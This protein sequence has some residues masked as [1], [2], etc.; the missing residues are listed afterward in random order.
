MEKY[1]DQLLQD[2]EA[3]IEIAKTPTESR[4]YEI[5]EWLSEEEEDRTAPVRELE[6]LTGIKQEQLPPSSLLADDQITKLTK[7]LIDLLNTHNWSFVMQTEVPEKFQ[8][9]CIRQ[10]FKQTVKVYKWKMGFFENC[11]PGTEHHTC[12]L[13]E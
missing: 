2:I 3:A 7:A 9:E 4:S 10:N 6:D 5:W 13:K 11:K 8:Y 1:V 12:A